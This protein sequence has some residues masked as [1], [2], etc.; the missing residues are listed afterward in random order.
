M[1]AWTV[2]RALALFVSFHAVGCS[3]GDS[4]SA[5]Q[6]TEVAEYLEAAAARGTRDHGRG[7]AAN[8][9]ECRKACPAGSACSGGL[10]CPAGQ[11]NCDGA[12]FDLQTSNAHCGACGTSCTSDQACVNAGCLAQTAKL[13]FI[14]G[15]DS[16]S[17][18]FPPPGGGIKVYLTLTNTGAAPTGPLSMTV[19]TSGN[20]RDFSMSF[21]ACLGQ[22]SLVPGDFCTIQA[23]FSPTTP[24][25]HT[26]DMIVSA[27][28]G[29]T[30]I[31]HFAGRGMVGDGQ[32]GCTSSL[33]CSP[34]LDCPTC[35]GTCL[36]AFSDLDRDGYGNSSPTTFC[37]RFNPLMYVSS[38]NDC[39]DRNPALFPGASICSPTD[40]NGRIICAHQRAG[41]D[42]DRR[43]PTG[44][45]RRLRGP[46]VGPRQPKMR[47][48]TWCQSGC[49][50]SSG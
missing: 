17:V 1:D 32:T 45:V 30:V 6:Q 46:V 40:P 19:T 49:A 3:S 25:L 10:C 5:D 36:T 38:S 4:R 13:A 33:D 47:N 24:G 16:T 22:Q 18:T 12:C 14:G 48:R 29:G 50:V 11:T 21:F 20:P 15:G 42:R 44:L 27:T 9:G 39:D 31:A 35:P 8:C 7:G 43:L 26:A 2:G 34:P 37:N 28:P 23:I 41:L